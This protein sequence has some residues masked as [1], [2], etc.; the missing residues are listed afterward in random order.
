[1]KIDG[2]ARVFIW[3]RKQSQP[4]IIH[5]R[6]MRFLKPTQSMLDLYGQNYKVIF[7]Y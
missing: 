2:T 5:T 6:I 4:C 3:L 7:S 1:M